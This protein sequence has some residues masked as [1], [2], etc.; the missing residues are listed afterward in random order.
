MASSG[1]E[2]PVRIE[3]QV[4]EVC[5]AAGCWMTLVASDADGR[6][7]KVKVED[8]EIVFPV[9]ARGKQAIAE[10][11]VEAIEMS[12]DRY[13]RF[14]AHLAQEQGREFDEKS[15]V[16]DGPFKVVQVRGAGARICS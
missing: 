16:G 7:I 14:Q 6:P 1:M 8:G 2:N 11:K 4:Q 9:S 5:Q 15:V 3:G 12:R 13:I 10:G